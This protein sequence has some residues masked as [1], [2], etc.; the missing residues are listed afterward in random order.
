MIQKK[1][2]SPNTY[3]IYMILGWICVVVSLFFV[4]IVFAAGGVIF[5][6]LLRSYSEKYKQHGTIM[7]IAAVAAGILGMLLGAIFVKYL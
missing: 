6:Y 5:G 3:M 1:Q 4:P 2:N 7:M